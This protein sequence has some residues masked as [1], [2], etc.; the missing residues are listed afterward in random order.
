M[1]DI[2]KIL[3]Y[4][5]CLI[6]WFLATL[7][8]FNIE[9]YHSLNLPFF[10]PPDAFYGIAWTITYIFIALSIYKIITNYRLEDLKRYFKILIINYLFNQSFTLV[11]FSLE[12]TF[13]G[14]ISCLGTFISTLFLYEETT[15][16]DEKSTKYLNPYVLLSLF[17]TILSLTIYLLNAR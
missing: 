11:F 6:P 5:L 3:T 15:N 13:L 10:T 8:P 17:A 16:L 9:F 14:F 2:K 7:F 1:I 4:I 12:N